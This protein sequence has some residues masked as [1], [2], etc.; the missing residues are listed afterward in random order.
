MNDLSPREERPAPPVEVDG[1]AHLF[2]ALGKQ[3]KTLRELMGLTQK[4]LAQRMHVSEDLVGSIERGVRLPQPDFL[5]RADVVME[6]RGLLRAAVPDVTEAL[7]KARIRHPDWFRRFA[8][9]EADSQALHYYEVQ[10][11]PGL[12]QTEAYARAVFRYRRPLLDEETVE[13][14]VSDRLSRQ[15]ILD[16]WPSP[17]FSFLLEEAV[18][19]RRI[20]GSAAHRE[21]LRRILDIGSRRTVNLQVMPLDIDKHPCLDSSFTLLH[22][23]GR[24]LVAYTETYGHA[25]LITDPERVRVY[26]ERYGIIRSLAL[27]PDESLALIEKMLGEGP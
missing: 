18:L 21:Q 26:S 17:T 27:R 8:D 3:I 24:Q 9:A 12:L 20:G 2:R 6:A 13:K 10:A 15:V 7:K 22:P 14:R 4:E 19:H 23:K 16:R 25:E 1:T 11:V 5:E